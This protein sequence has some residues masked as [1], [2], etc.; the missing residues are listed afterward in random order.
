MAR[1]RML[2][3]SISASVKI[4]SLSCDTCKLMATWI[5]PH[6]DMRGVFYSDPAMVKSAIF[7][8]RADVT[9]KQVSGY[10]QELSNAGLIEIFEANGDVWQ[11]W[12]GFVHNQVGLR[13]DR[14]TTEYPPPP[15]MDEAQEDTPRGE[16]PEASRN[17]A[18]EL[19]AEEKEKLKLNSSEEEDNITPSACAD[20][21]PASP[22]PEKPLKKPPKEKPAPL[23][24]GAR[25]FLC[26]FSA[27]RFA[28][29]AQKKAV[30]DLEQEHPVNFLPAATWA[31][32]KGVARGQAIG[33]M[34][35][36][37]PKWGKKKDN[38]RKSTTQSSTSANGENVGPDGGPRQTE[39][40]AFQ[41]IREWLQDS[42]SQ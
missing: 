25:A 12:P 31:A 34:R 29:A 6:L 16:M 4:N 13:A 2:N 27:K 35:K 10:L 30:L 1:G 18:D 24:D 42:P 14:E 3:K 37:L 11:C 28:N 21:Q 39:P 36:A 23:T 7:P 15:G 33:M 17:D 20:A 22:Q 26:L 8:R 19:P 32:E 40:A 9:I 38:G 5:I 41:G